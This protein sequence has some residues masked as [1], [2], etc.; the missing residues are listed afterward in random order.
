[1]VKVKINATQYDP[2]RGYWVRI[3]TLT[4]RTTLHG[5]GYHPTAEQAEEAARQ[6]LAG[7]RELEQA[8]HEPTPMG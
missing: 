5:T 6:W 2:L 7:Y 8:S 3:T 1:M 4:G